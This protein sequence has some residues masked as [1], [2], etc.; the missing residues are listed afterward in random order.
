[1][2]KTDPKHIAGCIDHTLLRPDA[3]EHDITRLCEEAAEHGF[4]AVC[5]HPSFVRRAK[6]ILSASHVKIC[7]VIGFPLGAHT[8][9][10]KQYEALEA[11]FNGADELDVMIH[12]GLV[13]SNNWK[14]VEEE[15]SG[16]VTITPGV[17]H[18]FIIETCSL[19]NDEKK[20]AAVM[21]MHTGA[22]FVKTSTGFGS[23]GAEIKDVKLIRSVTSGE[24][25]IKA[26][27]GIRTYR[28]VQEFMNA[29]AA[30]IGT[31]S[32]TAIINEALRRRK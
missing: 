2:K 17:V 21:I 19:T 32:G 22:E 1:M 15:V 27:G 4:F 18:K 28:Q 25:H 8:S 3:T 30:R 13:K 10:T 6:Q 23:G 24:I 9:Q 11:V 29:G 26:A 20:K 16:I 7:T 5:V 14:A 12:T 31:S